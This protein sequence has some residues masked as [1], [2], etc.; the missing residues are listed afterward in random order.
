M[1]EPIV[2]F[3]GRLT[4]DPE[5]RYTPAGAAV[6]KFSVAV[7]P[8][9]KKGNEWVDGDPTFLN[10]VTWNK[11][12]EAAADKLSK[13]AS[14]VVIGRLS[15]RSYETRDGERR[16]V[17][18]VQA[19]TVAIPVQRVGAVEERPRVTTVSGDDPWL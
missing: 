4:G 7:N 17:Y 9:V 5:L 6:A 13:G 8:R 12:A 15:Q 18:E 11:D 10:V 3:N 1:N 16:T 2:H 19:D 14:V